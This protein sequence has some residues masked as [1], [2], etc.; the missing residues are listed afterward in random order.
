MRQQLR[1]MR[2]VLGEQRE[3]VADLAAAWR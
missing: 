2:R 1:E 3:F